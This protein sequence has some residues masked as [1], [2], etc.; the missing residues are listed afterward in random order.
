MSDQPLNVTA[1]TIVPSRMV[2][3]TDGSIYFVPSQEDDAINDV[4]DKAI[5]DDI[6]RR[7]ESE[8]DSLGSEEDESDDNTPDHPDNW[9]PEHR[10]CQ[11]CHGYRNQ[12]PEHDSEDGKDSD[13]VSNIS[14]V[15]GDSF[16][17]N[18]QRCCHGKDCTHAQRGKCTFYHPKGEVTLIKDQ[19][20]FHGKYCTKDNCERQHP[21]G[22][23]YCKN[24]KDGKNCS[25]GKKCI[26]KHK[27][28]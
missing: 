6:R 21:D 15:T 13:D 16:I 28:H 26:F 22:K 3:N 27:T 17:P 18:K 23:G 5:E 11:I 9:Y 10:D 25:Y 24:E 12:F 1:F 20:C 4:I 2:V 19:I 14:D 7:S 8:S